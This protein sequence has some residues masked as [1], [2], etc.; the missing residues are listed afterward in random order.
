[1]TPIK[2]LEAMGRGKPVVM[3]ALPA[4][5]ELGEAA[6]AA[7]YYRP[8]DVE[9][10]A[11]RLDELLQDRAVATELLAAKQRVASGEQVPTAAAREVLS[12]RRRGRR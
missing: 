1:M 6:G 8:G 12:A 9:D 4:L 11:S 10:L 2:P 7:R 3:S 5:R